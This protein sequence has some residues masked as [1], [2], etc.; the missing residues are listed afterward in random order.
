MRSCHHIAPGLLF[1][2]LFVMP[3]F[4]QPGPPG[5]RDPIERVEHLKKI[6]LIEVLDLK[7]EQSVRLFARMNDHD[8]AKRDLFQ[9]KND[10]LDKI[11]RLVRN[12]A[13]EK[14]YAPQFQVL[15]D[16]D[17]KLVQEDHRF[18]EG[19]TDILSVEQRA[20]M[21]LF[22]R[23]FER[24]LRQAMREAARRRHAREGPP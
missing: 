5:D 21:L 15:N 8:K 18:F 11:E 7:E 3:A 2:S 10:V 23:H 24:E 12:G 19:L 14:E 20:K 6:R 13:D 9:Q 4:A 17:T 22:E 1:L 16:I